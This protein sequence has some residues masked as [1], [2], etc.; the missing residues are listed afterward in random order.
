MADSSISYRGYHFP[1]VVI[2]HAVWLYL[3]FPL[4]YRDVE[5]PRRHLLSAAQYHS[6]MQ[7]RFAIWRQAAGLVAS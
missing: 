3:R 6:T 2:A 1:G 5:D 7:R 4:S